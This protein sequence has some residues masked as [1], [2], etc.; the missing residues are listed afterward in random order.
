MALSTLLRETYIDDQHRGSSENQLLHQV[1]VSE[2]RCLMQC[3]L[4][5]T[6]TTSSCFSISY[7][8]ILILILVRW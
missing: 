8:H 4:A 2:I 3:R 7:I 1:R 6:N 5:Q